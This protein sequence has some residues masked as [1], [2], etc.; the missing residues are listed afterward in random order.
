M[1]SEATMFPKSYELCWKQDQKRAAKTFSILKVF[2]MMEL[3]EQ[4]QRNC[5]LF[6][7][8]FGNFYLK[9]SHE[10]FKLQLGP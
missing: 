7:C 5:F 2:S 9:K 10:K 4:K 8:C 6:C 1:L 3:E